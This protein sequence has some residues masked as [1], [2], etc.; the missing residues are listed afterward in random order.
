MS[1]QV[2]ATA[3]VETPVGQQAVDTPA[4]NRQQTNVISDPREIATVVMARMNFINAK[5]D[6]LTMAIKGLTDL[7]QQLV[8][9]YAGQMQVIEQLATRLKALEGTA[10]TNGVHTQAATSGT[11]SA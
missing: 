9:A 5:K 2:Q 6:E 4:A 7:T 3:T 1:E 11:H 10:G 8:R